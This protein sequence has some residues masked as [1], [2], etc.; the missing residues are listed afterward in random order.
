MLHYFSSQD[1]MISHTLARRF[2]WKDF[3]LFK[4][5]LPADK[6]LTVTLSGKDIIVPTS[7]AW[8]YLTKTSRAGDDGDGVT[9]DTE[10]ENGTLRVIRFADLNHAGVFNSKDLRRG[11]VS[12]VRRQCERVDA[13]TVSGVAINEPQLAV[14]I[15]E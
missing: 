11:V 9:G 3:I 14:D 12:I 1:M 10:W 4:E 15:P 6:L 5:D 7:D 13:S 8:N 2:F